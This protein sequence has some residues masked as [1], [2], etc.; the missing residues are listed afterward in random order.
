[1]DFSLHTYSC[2]FYKAS[3]YLIC[4]AYDAV[5]EEILDDGSCTVTFEAYGNT[6][7]TQVGAITRWELKHFPW[8][9]TNS[10]GGLDVVMGIKIS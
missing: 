4:S 8:V 9:W 7:V 5:I 1:M 2:N 10:V 3:F 6:D